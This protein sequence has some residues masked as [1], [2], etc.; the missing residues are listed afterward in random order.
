MDMEW[1]ARNT[2]GDPVGREPVFKQESELLQELGF[3]GDSEAPITLNIGPQWIELVATLQQLVRERLA[4]RR[5]TIEV[6]PTSNLIIGGYRDYAELP[7]QTMVENGLTVSINTDDPGLFMT[8]LPNEYASLYQALVGPMNHRDAAA[9][10]EA[11]HR[12]GTRS[13]FLGRNVPVGIT[14][15]ELLS[16]KNRKLLFKYQPPT[17]DL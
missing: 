2:T 3:E 4:H 1:S 16:K 15:Y 12:D 13:T 11:R 10:L 9:W 6:N 14:A 5:V 8:S 7:Y 17:D